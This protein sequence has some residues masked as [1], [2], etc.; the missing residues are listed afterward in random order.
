MDR[1]HYQYGMGNI[2]QLIDSEGPITFFRYDRLF[3][4]HLTKSQNLT[5][6][7]TKAK[8]S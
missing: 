4:K 2:E 6:Y 5:L 7:I 8:F 3:E 1:R